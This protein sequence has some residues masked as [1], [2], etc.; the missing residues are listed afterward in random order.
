MSS[1]AVAAATP[2]PS[3][4]ASEALLT[5][6]E[7]GKLDS[8]GAGLRTSSRWSA[9]AVGE[10]RS[11]ECAG[12]AGVVA[13]ETRLIVTL[14]EVYVLAVPLASVMAASAAPVVACTASA[15]VSAAAHVV[16]PWGAAEEG[17]V[18]AVVMAGVFLAE[19]RRVSVAV[20]G[21]AERLSSNGLTT[22]LKALGQVRVPKRGMDLASQ[23]VLASWIRRLDAIESACKIQDKLPA[24]SF[25][26]WS[27]PIRRGGRGSAPTTTEEGCVYALEEALLPVFVAYSSSMGLFV[28]IG[29]VLFTERADMSSTVIYRRRCDREG[30]FKRL[31]EGNNKSEGAWATI[32]VATPRSSP[33]SPP[34]K[35]EK[36]NHS[37]WF[38]SRDLQPIQICIVGEVK[39]S[40]EFCLQEHTLHT[41]LYIHWEL[42]K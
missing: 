28:L 7:R 25:E 22:L 4:S 10:T 38:R 20:A 32:F 33:L 29:S 34:L 11:M 15:C 16:V 19:R 18:V 39:K 42:R 24:G 27:Q 12:G 6:R 14:R 36:P 40:K 31:R 9:L 2:S 8:D 1:A 13:G 17:R 3:E 30:L 21:V 35:V 37:W 26:P 41:E 23:A 5:R